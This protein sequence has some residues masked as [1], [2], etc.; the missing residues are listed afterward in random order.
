MIRTM[1]ESGRFGRRLYQRMAA[2]TTLCL[3]AGCF[4]AVP[5]QAEET[6]LKGTVLWGPVK[7]GPSKVGQ[8]E[9][10]PLRATFAVYAGEEKIAEFESDRFGAFEVSLPPGEYTI[11]PHEKTPVPY[12][13]N[14]TTQVTVP[15]DGFADVTIRLDTGMR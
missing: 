8:E 11:V 7:P 6:G 12:A 1:S 15:D 4:A 10:A 2:L 3:V 9:E 14:Q 5:V 13:T